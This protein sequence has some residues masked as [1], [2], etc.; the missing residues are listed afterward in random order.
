MSS[1]CRAWLA[2]FVLLMPGLAIARDE[3]PSRHNVLILTVDCLR[4]DHL[5]LSGYERPTT[6]NLDAFAADAWVFEN[7]FATSAWTSPGIVSMLTGYNPP[8]HAQNG[9]HAH[10]DRVLASA[11]RVF[12]AAGYMTIG[13]NASGPNYGGIGLRREVGAVDFEAFVRARAEEPDN[14]PFIAW[15]H[16]KEPHLPYQ[17]SAANAGRFSGGIA[18]TPGVEAVRRFR[19][20]FRDPAT[21]VSFRHAGPVAFGPGDAEAVR[22]LYDETVRDADDHLGRAFAALRETGLID[23]TLVV[24]SADHGEELL[25]HGWVGHASTSYDGKLT[26]ELVRIPLIIR[27]PGAEGGRSDALVSGVDL[28]PSL[29]EWLGLDPAAVSPPMQGV[30]LAPLV[31]GTAETVRDYVFQQTTRKGWTTPPDEMWRR[32]TAVRTRDRK[33]IWIPPEAGRR[34]RLEGYDL[35]ADPGEHHDLYPSQPGRFA[36]LEYA[37]NRWDLSNQKTAAAL[38]T[39]GGRELA[40]AQQEALGEGD[41]LRAIQAWQRLHRMHRTWGLEEAPFRLQRADG[42]AWRELHR[43]ATLLL[44]DAL[45][46]EAGSVEAGSGA[47]DGITSR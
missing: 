42:A 22:A 23:R 41:L 20:I 35:A 43:D 24:V 12:D 5:S 47:T 19:V 36:D 29:F 38:V 17:A 8:V 15:L 7:A 25:E 27:V 4:P 21:K 2:W 9:R 16:S 14:D 1:L 13:R 39:A 6:P 11:L 46:R 37:R 45:A 18:I 28:M 33:L 32:V 44:S 31:A 34:A 40:R 10:Y 3:P 30:S 26:D